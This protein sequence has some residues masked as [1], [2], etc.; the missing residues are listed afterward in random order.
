MRYQIIAQRS[1]VLVNRVFTPSH[2]PSYP[3]SAIVTHESRNS[4]DK[5]EFLAC[6]CK[7]VF[8]APRTTG[9]TTCDSLIRTSYETLNDE[10]Y[11]DSLPNPE[12]IPQPNGVDDSV[13]EARREAPLAGRMWRRPNG[14]RGRK[15]VEGGET[16]RGEGGG[17]RGEEKGKREGERERERGRLGS[18]QLSFPSQP[19][20][21]P[22][23]AL[24]TPSYPFAPLPPPPP[25]S[26]PP[27]PPPPVITAK[28]RFLRSRGSAKPT[29]ESGGCNGW[30]KIKGFKC[31]GERQPAC[32]EHE[33]SPP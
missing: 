23:A 10:Q 8:S 12:T 28:L 13:G 11:R 17:G 7:L 33:S 31:G 19:S 16:G 20:P 3:V 29:F 14:R 2:H 27:P 25:P 9:G 24:L 21:P 18:I 4:E 22:P 32:W 15:R 26:S 6:R 1:D 5:L 30:L